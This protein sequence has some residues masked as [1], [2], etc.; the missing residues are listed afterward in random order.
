MASKPGNETEP[1]NKKAKQLAAQDEVLMRE[2]DEAVRQDDL[3]E[4]ASTYGKPLLGVLLAGIIGFGGYLFWDSQVEGELESQSESLVAALDQ[5]EA[6]NLSAAGD[7][8]AS[9]AS[10]SD[11]GAGTTA[12][13]LQASL[14]MQEGRTQEAVGLFAQVA[15]D[16]D[17]PPAMRD[18]ATIREVTASYDQ[19]EPATV[20]ERLGA[21]LTWML[22]LPSVIRSA[23]STSSS[24]A[25]ASKSCLRASVAARM[26]ALPIRCV[27]LDANEPMSCGPVSLSAV[28]T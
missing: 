22:P 26:T 12:T 16:E 28:S 21:P 6:G 7:L 24:S 20:I 13:L 10:E 19:L 5:A 15:A 11:G 8:A 9:L 27:P 17:A 18:L 2:I 4:F 14:A 1:E 25:A 3:A 23:A